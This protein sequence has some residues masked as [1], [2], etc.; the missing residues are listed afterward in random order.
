VESLT[1]S[2]LTLI[3]DKSLRQQMGANGQQKALVYDWSHIAERILDFYQETLDKG[4]SHQA[5]PEPA[6]EPVG[7]ASGK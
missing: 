1:K 3:E 5:N 7:M 6:A 2:L 4:P